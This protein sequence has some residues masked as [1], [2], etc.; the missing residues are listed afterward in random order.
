MEN[1]KIIKALI[2]A[3]IAETSDKELASLLAKIPGMIDEMKETEDG[4]TAAVVTLGKILEKK[5]RAFREY[6]ESAPRKVRVAP[7]Y[8]R[9]NDVYWRKF[10]HK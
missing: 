3:A 8:Q 10:D 5:D 1:R 7:E 6:G 9:F 2:D 4:L